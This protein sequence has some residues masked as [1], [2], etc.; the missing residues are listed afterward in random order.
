MLK[1]ENVQFI[2]NEVLKKRNNSHAI[3]FDAC[4]KKMIHC[5]CN[6]SCKNVKPKSWKDA[7]SKGW[8]QSI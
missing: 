4:V 3:Y 8:M 7:R 5:W 6:P 1:V 2:T